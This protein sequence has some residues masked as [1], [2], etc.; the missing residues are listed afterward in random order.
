MKKE[1]VELR[2]AMSLKAELSHVKELEDG[3]G[4]SYG[5]HYKTNG[6]TRIGTLPIGYADGFTRLYSFKAHGLINGEKNQS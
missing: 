4:I 6:P 3:M 2:E 1:N 5:L